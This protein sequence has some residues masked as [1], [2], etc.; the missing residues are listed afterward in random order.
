MPRNYGLLKI[1]RIGAE[2]RA[3]WKGKIC[4]VAFLV[5]PLHRDPEEDSA[6]L[7]RCGANS[8]TET[9]R[10]APNGTKTEPDLLTT[11]KRRLELWQNFIT[12]FER[13]TIPRPRVQAG[14][15]LYGAA[16]YL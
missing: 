15:L 3:N 1:A 6:T 11:Q 8:L 5:V 7:Q 14:T 12:N 10:L 4:R 13:T 2:N 9:R 16:D